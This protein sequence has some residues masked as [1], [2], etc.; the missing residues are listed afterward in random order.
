MTQNAKAAY[1]LRGKRRWALTV[2]QELCLDTTR[3]DESVQGTPIVNRLEDLQSLLHYIR[4]EPWGAFSFYRSFVTVPFE[5]GDSK[6]RPPRQSG[7]PDAL[8]QKHRPSRSCRSSSR[9][10]VRSLTPVH[11]SD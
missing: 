8:E 1:A 6:V 3:R 9:A 4:L 5:K 7:E 10:A 2:R 11:R